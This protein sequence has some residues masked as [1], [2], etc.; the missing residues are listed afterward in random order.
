M[1]TFTRTSALSNEFHNL[2]SDI[3]TLL[4]EAAALSGDELAVVK[5]KIQARVVTAKAS[6]LQLGDEVSAGA[7]KLAREA[8]EEVHAEPWKAVGIGAALGLL[9]GLAFARR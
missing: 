9:L 2:L 7:S 6:A 4:K 1:N 3:E 8:N 5:D